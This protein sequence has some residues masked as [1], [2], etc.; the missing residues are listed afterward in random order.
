MGGQEGLD[1]ILQS[2]SPNDSIL[3]FASIYYLVSWIILIGSWAEKQYNGIQTGHMNMFFSLILM[4][5]GLLYSQGNKPHNNSNTAPS[6]SDFYSMHTLVAFDVVCTGFIALTTTRESLYIYCKHA[7]KKDTRKKIGKKRKA[8]QNKN[9][10][11]LGYQKY[12]LDN[13]GTEYTFSDW[14]D[15]EGAGD[16]TGFHKGYYGKVKDP[17]SNLYEPVA[18]LLFSVI[19]LRFVAGICI[20][21]LA[22]FFSNNE[23]IPKSMKPSTGR[24]KVAFAGFYFIIILISFI[25]YGEVKKKARNKGVTTE[26]MYRCKSIL[27]DEGVDTDKL[28]GTITQTKPNLKP[29]KFEL[30]GE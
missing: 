10:Q 9:E 20:V 26:E 28:I 8:V 4:S 19:L 12:L 25:L 5:Y 11:K 24:S 3:I 27:D 13:P 18:I 23:L 21:I 7:L 14:Q 1:K 30:S 15:N 22:A 29:K 17:L 6:D 2:I 16:F